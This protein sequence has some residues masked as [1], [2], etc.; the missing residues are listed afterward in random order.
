MGEYRHGSG[1]YVQSEA[2]PSQ[3]PGQI[4]DQ[5]V[6]AFFKAVRDL[7]L[8]AVAIRQRVAEWIASPPPDH[9]VLIDPDLDAREILLTGIRKLTTWPVEA[10]TIQEA[11]KSDALLAAIP[12]SCGRRSVRLLIRGVRVAI[13]AIDYLHSPRPRL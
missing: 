5:H 13:A 7:R 6:V 3:T 10:M 4:L 8:P 12:L 11:A 9:F 1:V 2:A